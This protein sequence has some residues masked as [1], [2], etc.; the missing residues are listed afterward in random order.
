MELKYPIIIVI[1]IIIIVYILFIYKAKINNSEKRIVANTDY[2]KLHEMYQQKLKQY[3]V[4][5]K[6]LIILFTVSALLSSILI[7]RPNSE[8]K[9][10]S[11]IGYRDIM[12]SMDISASVN[13]LNMQIIEELK[14]VINNLEGDRV[15]INMF[16]TSNSL[17]VPLT[18]DY[19]YVIDVLDELK[20]SCSLNTL[21]NY[22]D[23]IQ[24]DDELFYSKYYI[25]AGTLY[26]NET[27]G[28]SLIAEGLVSA[29]YN[30]PDLEDKERSRIIIFTTDND[31]NGEPLVTLSDA[32][33]LVK[34]HDVSLYVIVPDFTTDED[35]I[36]MEDATKIANG[37][38]YVSGNE[39]NAKSIVKE[40]EE[41]EI[42]ADE[43]EEV[44]LV[45]DKP[46]ILFILLL[47]LISIINVYSVR[48]KL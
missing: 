37:N 24:Y 30:F 5:K 45:V 36:E 4:A 20:E 3:S 29:L 8:T 11:Q 25:T 18:N 15:G 12:I 9:I 48:S 21:E 14:E 22:L 2:I 44:K 46:E 26:Q 38:F 47:I 27:R 40:I 17:I 19:K 34:K 41:K 32:A 42:I 7:A 28:S 43:N 16:N 23:I 13:E 33:S 31:L 10:E 35:K 6:N 1:C 39:E